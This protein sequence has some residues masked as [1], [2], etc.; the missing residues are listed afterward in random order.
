MDD[1]KKIIW[2][3]SYPKSGN[4]WFR[5]F[6]TALLNPELKE[7]DI[8]N[9]LPSTIASSRQ[10][11]DELSGIESSDLTSDE[12]D[13]LRPQIYRENAIESK[14]TVYHK[15]HDA[16][17]VLPDGT[18]L[19]PAD[20]TQGVL[21][22]IRNPL[23]VAVSF[24]N[25][26]NTSIDRTI[27]IMNNRDYAFCDK[28]S[29]LHNQLRQRL[30]TWSGHVKSWT[31]ES[32]LPVMVIRYE[33]MLTDTMKVFSKAIAFM[34]IER[35]EADIQKA[36]A[37]SSFEQLKKQEESKGFSEKSAKSERFFRKGTAGDWRTTL[38]AEQAQL[39]REAHGLTMLK[40][41]Y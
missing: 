19:F 20:I 24:A 18:I 26:L 22:F 1:P 36:I 29:K 39:I 6:L 31:E 32:G 17:Q 15:I 37:L 21:Y 16:W 30:S 9:M 27:E 41:G 35:Q 33:D 13:S 3:A 28:N 5:A 12:I 8:N 34:G 7:V 23:D 40:F 2:L 10:L 11:F 14:E 4:T 25:H 38:T